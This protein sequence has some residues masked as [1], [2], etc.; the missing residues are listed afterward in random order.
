MFHIKFNPYEC[1]YSIIY[2]D[3]MHRLFAHLADRK[4]INNANGYGL[5]TSKKTATGNSKIRDCHW[6]E[7][8]KLIYN[9]HCDFGYLRF[10]QEQQRQNWSVIFLCPLYKRVSKCPEVSYFSFI[11]TTTFN[12]YK[13]QNNVSVQKLIQN[14]ISDM[15]IKTH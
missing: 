15:L 6:V 1:L 7:R 13:R 5:L 2:Y 8:N 9:T 12:P 11:F 10:G 3:C 14:R 4:W